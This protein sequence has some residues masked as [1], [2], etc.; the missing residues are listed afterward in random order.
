MAL[1]LSLVYFTQ[2]TVHLPDQTLKVMF[3]EHGLGASAVDALFALAT[4]AWLIK[5]LYGLL[6]DFVPLWGSRRRSYLLLS[7]ALSTAAVLSILML[8]I[9]VPLPL[10]A[11]LGIM[12]LGMAFTDVVADGLMVERGQAEKLTGAFQSA[13]WAAVSVSSIIERRYCRRR[14]IRPYFKAFFLAETPQ[15]IYRAGI[16]RGTHLS[17]LPGG[18]AG[19]SHRYAFWLPGYD[20]NT[21]NS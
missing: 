7:I 12:G 3:K 14:H 18:D 1:L 6:S 13:Q 4:S 20:Y 8:N 17:C 5:P 21:G 19:Y 15:H 9:S 16:M 2:N 10:V 11:L